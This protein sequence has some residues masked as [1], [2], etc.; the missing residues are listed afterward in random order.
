M[1]PQQII[2]RAKQYY[3]NPTQHFDT[4]RA[5]TLGINLETEPDEHTFT[6]ALVK[7]ASNAG[8][9]SSGGANM[10]VS[11]IAE[12][13]VQQIQP[14]FNDYKLTGLLSS[15][16][17]AAGKADVEKSIRE[18]STG[19]RLG[20]TGFTHTPALLQYEKNGEQ[21]V[22]YVE[23]TSPLEQ[24][25]KFSSVIREPEESAYR[26]DLEDGEFNIYG[27]NGADKG[28]RLPEHY[29]TA[30]DYRKAREL[31]SQ[32]LLGFEKNTIG[33]M[34]GL[35]DMIANGLISF[36]DDE[37]QYWNQSP[38]RNWED[39]TSRID[40]MVVSDS[41]GKSVEDVIVNPTKEKF[42]LMENVGRGIFVS[43]QAETWDQSIALMGS[44]QD[45]EILL[46]DHETVNHVRNEQQFSEDYLRSQIL[47]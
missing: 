29:V 10:V 33:N 35:G 12:A 8:V 44:I 24:R 37:S 11:N 14:G 46:T 27:E 28:V 7:A 47:T 19:E 9:T 6:R 45:P 43:Q 2:D 31:E 20:S 15:E 21:K 13:A 42:Q 25:P 26:T 38:D 16:S 30:F 1:T 4:D 18:T 32:G 40:G 17:I 34:A 5:E 3:N 23:Q 41:F 22:M 36:V 39:N